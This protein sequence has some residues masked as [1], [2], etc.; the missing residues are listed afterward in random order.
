MTKLFKVAKFEYT[1]NVF[2]KRFWVALLLVPLLFILFSLISTFISF[3]SVDTR[4]VGLID[5]AGI[6]TQAQKLKEKP[7]GLFEI[8]IEFVPF[9]DENAAK[10]KPVWRGNIK[11]ISLSRKITLQVMR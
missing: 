5:R 11:V 3:K 2:T 6:I 1:R 8:Q 4:P 9:T 7:G 10:K